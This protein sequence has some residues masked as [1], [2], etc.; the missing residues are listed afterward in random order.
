MLLF[1][2][3]DLTI[4]LHQQ[5]GPSADVSYLISVP[6]DFPGPYLLAYSETKLKGNGLKIILVLDHFR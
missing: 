3:C 5:H 6:P 4:D 2:V 1:M